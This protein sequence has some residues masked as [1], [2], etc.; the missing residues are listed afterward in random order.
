MSQQDLPKAEEKEEE[1]GLQLDLHE[2]VEGGD[3][4]TNFSTMLLKLIFKADQ[5]NRELLRKGF[6]NAVKTVEMW[7][8]G[9]T[10][11]IPN[12]PYD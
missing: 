5:H 1:M 2:I 7:R 8:T 3:R 11:E 9:K 4:Q 10:E 12:L 6:P